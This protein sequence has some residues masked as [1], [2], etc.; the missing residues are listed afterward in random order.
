MEE[1]VQSSNINQKWLENIYENIKNI[2][3]HER[4]AKEGCES[5][6]VYF[7]IPQ[8]TRQI[9]LGDIQFKNLSFFLTEFHLLISDLTPVLNDKDVEY[10][11]ET[12]KKIEKGLKTEQLFIN[13][14]Y[15]RSRKLKET[16][17]TPFFYET[18][19]FLGELKIEL[20]KKIKNILY[21]PSSPHY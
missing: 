5:L 19:N 17:L 13:K 15:D 11:R 9:V 2:E 12:I 8:D 1:F 4:L 21:I 10:F 7:G 18:L 14:V 3:E 16:K 20:F 6:M